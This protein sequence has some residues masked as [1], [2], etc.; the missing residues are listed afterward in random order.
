MTEI[1]QI[2]LEILEPH[3]FTAH[4]AYNSHNHYYYHD[5]Q[6]TLR[7]I[8]TQVKL[9]QWDDG[10]SRQTFPASVTFV[11]LCDPNSLQIIEDWAKT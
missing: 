8:G 4:R 3:G 5:K 11:D 10:P 7:L 6:K 2:L 1:E 9:V